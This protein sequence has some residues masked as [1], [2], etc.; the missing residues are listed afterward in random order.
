MANSITVKDVEAGYG[1]VKVLHGVSL[2]VSNGETVVLLGSNGN[3]KSTLIKCIMGIIA[4]SSGEIS[5]DLEGERVN[6]IGLMPEQIV[7][8]CI[9]LVPEGRRIFSALTV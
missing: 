9:A 6:L 1:S 8:L 7:D 4:P 3:G 2:S 5:V